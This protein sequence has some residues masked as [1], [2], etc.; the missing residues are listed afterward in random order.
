[1]IEIK[2]VS[3]EFEKKIEKGSIKF[4]ADNNISFDVKDGEILGLLGPNGAG[5]TTL[6]RILAGIMKPS[7]GNVFFDDKNYSNNANEIKK[8]ISFLSGVVLTLLFLSLFIG[9]SLIFLFFS[10]SILSSL[11]SPCFSSSI[12]LIE[13]LN[14]VG[15]FKFSEENKKDF[16]PIGFLRVGITSL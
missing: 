5:K 14:V 4:L 15:L 1:M 7:S 13:Y 12:L 16:F 11:S 9:F 8:N 10:F 2:N 3:K 6:L